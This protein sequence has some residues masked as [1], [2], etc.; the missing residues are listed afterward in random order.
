MVKKNIRIALSNTDSILLIQIVLDQK[1]TY[2]NLN[3]LGFGKKLIYDCS[4][5]KS[6]FNSDGLYVFRA[7]I[8]LL[9]D[10]HKFN[11]EAQS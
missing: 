3:A 5:D 10:T 4:L 1:I 9:V 6:S 2:E 11:L 8:P 7:L